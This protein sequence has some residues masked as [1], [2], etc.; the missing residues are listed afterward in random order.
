MTKKPRREYTYYIRNNSMTYDF[1]YAWH[2]N[3]RWY[4]RGSK[5]YFCCSVY[6]L[7]HMCLT[8]LIPLFPEN[9]LYLSLVFSL[10]RLSWF[11]SY[12]SLTTL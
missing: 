12:V 2:T 11:S 1:I 3:G 7:Y 4:L 8:H 10:Y 6:V 5:V 9:I